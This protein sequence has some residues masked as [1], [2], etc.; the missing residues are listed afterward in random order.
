MVAAFLGCQDE[1]IRTQTIYMQRRRGDFMRRGC[2]VM[3]IA[4]ASALLASPVYAQDHAA[5]TV[6]G[7]IQQQYNMVKRNMLAAAD[8]MPESNYDFKPVPEERSYGQWVAHIADAQT[9][10]CSGI[11]GDHKMSHAA[12]MT[13]KAD[14]VGAL[15]MS[16]DTCDAAYAGLTASNASDPV[17]LF[18]GK[19]P[20]LAA[21]TFNAEHDNEAYG[22]M[23]VYMRLKGIVPPSTADSPEMRKR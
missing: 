6:A 2:S 4:L 19:Q 16:F 14:L 5:P 18:R 13:S 7:A 1:K 22:S 9:M 17:P 3:G 21:L 11:T 20:R 8:K 23:S 15:K 10:I 12:A